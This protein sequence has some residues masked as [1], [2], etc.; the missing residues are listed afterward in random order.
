MGPGRRRAGLHGINVGYEEAFVNTVSISHHE[1]TQFQQMIHRLAGIHM[2]EAKKPLMIGRLSK[3]LRHYD[4]PSFRDY[5][6]LVMR[7]KAELQ[8]AIDLLTTNET[9]FFREP[10][11]MDFLRDHV[12]PAHDRASPF[13]IWSAACSS[14]EEVYTLAMLTADIL[15]DGPW[16]VIGS[17]ISSR[18][19]EKARKGHYSMER[20]EGIPQAY[21][22]RFCLKGIGSQQGTFMIDAPLRERVRFM[23]V[24]LIGPMPR[25]GL[26]HVIFLRNVMIYFDQKTKTQIV[27]RML[28][29]LRPGGYFIVSHSESMAGVNDTLEAVR[30]SIYRKPLGHG[31]G[32]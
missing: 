5:Y 18:V 28:P 14:G 31:H 15:G 17:D 11:H 32:A 23:S 20:T 16:E 29:L 1:F 22:R 9:Y 2:S 10:K 25:L 12:L 19:L 30:P 26:F 24:N 13:R 6:E 8:V 21:L 3:R 4:L 27:A 7:D